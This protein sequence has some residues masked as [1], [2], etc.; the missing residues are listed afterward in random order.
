MLYALQQLL[1][2]VPIASL[3][4]ALAFGYATA[5]AVTKRADITYGALFAAAGHLFLLVAHTGWNVLFLTFPAALSLGALAA[6]TLVAGGGVVIGRQ[7]VAPLARVSPNALTVASLG[8]LLVLMEAAR[9]ASGTRELWLPPFLN[10]PLRLW[11]GEEGTASLT[12][13]QALNSLVL[14][15][16]VAGGG[17]FLAASRWGRHWRAVCDDP[18][19]AELCGVQ[20]ARIFAGAYGLAALFAA[21][22]GLLATAHYGTMDFGAGILFGLKIVLIAAAGGHSHPL[23]AAAGAALFGFGETLWSGYG[24]VAW[25]DTVMLGALVALLVISRRERVLV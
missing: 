8:L 15:L 22:A 10:T 13:L 6:V 1:N 3:Y 18:L 24:P 12:L 2:A 19:A 16:L 20:A 14:L 7:V 25:R 4:A 11:R 5:F 9:L 21:L 23:R 17:W